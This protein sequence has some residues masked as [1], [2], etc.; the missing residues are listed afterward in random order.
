MNKQS[1]KQ[2]NKEG[3]HGLTLQGSQA[4]SWRRLLQRFCLPAAL[5]VAQAAP[6]KWRLQEARACLCWLH[7]CLLLGS[8]SLLN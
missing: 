7:V 6:Q 8:R 5:P 3:A 4:E 2:S 1:N